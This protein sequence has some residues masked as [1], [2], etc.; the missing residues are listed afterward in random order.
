[1]FRRR[2][3]PPSTAAASEPS[4]VVEIDEQNFLDRTAG[5]FTIV[6]FWAPW[7]PPCRSFSPVFEAAARDRS[8]QVVFGRCNVDT[9]P[10]VAAMLGIASIPTVV[11][12]GPDGSEV[13]RAV[14]VLS[15]PQLG[16]LVDRLE[17]AAAE[18]RSA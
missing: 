17:A 12:F 13:G 16:Q 5:G 14:G 2:H 10:R 7:C 15:R 8:G 6:D 18:D 3:S 11:V 9:S 4:P 1:M